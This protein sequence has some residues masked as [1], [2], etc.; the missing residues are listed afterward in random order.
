MSVEK[1][2]NCNSY[3]Q[4]FNIDNTEEFNNKIQ[5][6]DDNIIKVFI[7]TADW[8]AACHKLKPVINDHIIKYSKNQN[9]CFAYININN[10]IS[11]SELFKISTIP[12]IIIQKNK[13]NT[14]VNAH[15]FTKLYKYLDDLLTN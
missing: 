13:I 6:L 3:Q 2:T 8:C 12:T 9:I 15:E 11:L 7:F 5:N 14:R 1:Q 4:V 10:C